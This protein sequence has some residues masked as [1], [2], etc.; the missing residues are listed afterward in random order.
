VLYKTPGAIHG[1]RRD[2]MFLYQ[3]SAIHGTRRDLDIL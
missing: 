3:T 1:T 2:L